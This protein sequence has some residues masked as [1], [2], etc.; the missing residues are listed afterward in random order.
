MRA[1]RYHEKHT[2]HFQISAGSSHSLPRE[3]IIQKLETINCVS[4]DGTSEKTTTEL[5]FP[6]FLLSFSRNNLHFSPPQVKTTRFYF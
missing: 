6:C 5:F 3:E 2:K 1:N 4:N